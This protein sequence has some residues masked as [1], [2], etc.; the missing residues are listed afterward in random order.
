M[1]PKPV[2]QW[3]SVW[4]E[5]Q[6]EIQMWLSQTFQGEEMRERFEWKKNPFPHFAA[7]LE[8]VKICRRVYAMSKQTLV[9]AVG[10][11]HCR[12]GRC[13][14]GEC[15][16]TSNP[17]FYECKCKPPFQGP[18]CRTSKTFFYRHTSY[19]Y[20]LNRYNLNKSSLFTFLP[21][22][23]CVSPARVRMVEPVSGKVKM[24][25]TASVLQATEGVSA[26]LVNAQRLR[27][28]FNFSGVTHALSHPNT[29]FL[30]RPGWLLWGWWRVVPWQ[31]EWDRWWLW[32]PLLELS[33]HPGERSWSLRQLW[34]PRWTWPAQLLQVRR[35]WMHDFLFSGW[36]SAGN[37]EK[38]G[39]R[40]TLWTKGFYFSSYSQFTTS[41]LPKPAEF[42]LSQHLGAVQTCFALGLQKMQ[43]FENGH[44]HLQ[45]ADCLSLYHKITLPST[46][47]ICVLQLQLF[48]CTLSYEKTY[49][50]SLRYM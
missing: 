11:K 49:V 27:F 35:K 7:G 23:Q 33:L 19:L 29:D 44:T 30:C 24:T 8:I 47:L 10:P 26:M 37:K 12:K 25:L 2:P 13:G 22:L 4:G 50:W 1:Q 38:D 21:Q 16:L 6:K 41:Q 32:M 39:D 36:S 20:S 43:H 18:N 42:C 40:F 34:K 48:W 9:I 46:H 3:W 5:A 14:R 17:P 15:V 31:C 45:S 28:S